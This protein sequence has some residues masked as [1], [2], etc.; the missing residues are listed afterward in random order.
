MPPD[1]PDGPERYAVLAGP[2]DAETEVRRSRFLCR[3][4]RVAGEDAARAAVAEARA[5][6]RLARHHC[7]AFVIGPDR[8]LR[9]SSDDGEPAGT[10]GAPMLD[11]LAQHDT[12]HPGA[13]L[14]DVVAI[15]VRYFG[16]VLLGAGGLVRA[17]SDAVS[18]ALDAAG[19]VA[20]ERHQRFGLL[21][22]HDRAG[23][24]EYEL[25]LAGV[26]TEPPEYGARGV[27]L[28]LGVPADDEAVS[29]LE[30]RVAAV[31]QGAGR[32]EPAGEGWV[33]LA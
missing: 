32:L 21:A 7:T 20:R 1:V 26:D 15:V 23:R 28:R 27:L 9:R 12:G 29:R 4:R 2:V 5:E 6:H 14:S 22:P 13:P 33:D 30:A 16:G 8:R 24:W 3:L 31:T 18:T 10:A 25:R 17:Y 19:F 11:A